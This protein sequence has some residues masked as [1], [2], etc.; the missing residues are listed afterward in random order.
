MIVSFWY[1]ILYYKNVVYII[2]YQFEKENESLYSRDSKVTIFQKNI[3]IAYLHR[4]IK[5]KNYREQNECKIMRKIERNTRKWTIK[6][7]YF[8]PGIPF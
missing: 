4:Q 2:L 1:I 3:I 5:I 8:L 6:D 7:D